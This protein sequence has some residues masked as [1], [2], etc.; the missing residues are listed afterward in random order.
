ML[1]KTRTNLEQDAINTVREYIQEKRV[2]LWMNWDITQPD[3]LVTA[4][5]WFYDTMTEVVEYA[6]AKAE[7]IEKETE[8]WEHEKLPE[9]E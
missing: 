4:A 3:S 1:Q 9:S 6:E 8:Q 5:E 7:S 2:T